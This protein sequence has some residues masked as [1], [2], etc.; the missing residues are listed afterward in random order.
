MKKN[1]LSILTAASILSLSLLTLG[2]TSKSMDYQGY[3]APAKEWESSGNDGLG[4]ASVSTAAKNI[5]ER[6]LGGNNEDASRGVV[7]PDTSSSSEMK[8]GFRDI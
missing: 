5:S 2:C 8:G 7:A 3:S 4:A 6:D 1:I